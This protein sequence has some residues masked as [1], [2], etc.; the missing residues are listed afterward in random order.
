MIRIR[1]IK[2]SLDADRDD[3]LRAAAKAL[4]IDPRQI[5]SLTLVRRSIDSRKKEDVHFRFIPADDFSG[6][7][8]GCAAAIR[9]DLN[10]Y[11]PE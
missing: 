6:A 5:Q 8:G 2:Q 7:L 10:E 9:W 4:H 1:E 3:L 11:I